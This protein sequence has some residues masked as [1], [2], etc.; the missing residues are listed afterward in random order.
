MQLL[1]KANNYMPE[2]NKPLQRFCEGVIQY[3]RSLQIIATYCD[4]RKHLHKTLR[5]VN[6]CLQT[7]YL[8]KAPDKWRTLIRPNVDKISHDKNNMKFVNRY[9]SVTEVHYRRGFRT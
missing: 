8:N 1:P 2:N 6:I 9:L 3:L 7:S 4:G 5:I